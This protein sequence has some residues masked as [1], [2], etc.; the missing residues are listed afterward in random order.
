M[1]IRTIEGYKANLAKIPCK[2]EGGSAIAS[3]SF[4]VSGRHAVDAKPAGR[5]SFRGIDMPSWVLRR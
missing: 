1:K 3:G 2:Y 4:S 5:T